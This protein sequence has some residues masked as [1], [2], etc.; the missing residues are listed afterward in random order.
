MAN[1]QIDLAVKLGVVSEAYLE[2]C[3]QLGLRYP[4]LCSSI[5]AVCESAAAQQ[6]EGRP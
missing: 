1:F 2:G 3:Y 6:P 4:D 5:Y